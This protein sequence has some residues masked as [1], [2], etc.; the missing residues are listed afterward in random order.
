MAVKE[1]N[2]ICRERL[3]QGSRYHIRYSD[4]TLK[5]GH[6]PNMF[7]YESLMDFLGYNDVIHPKKDSIVQNI[8]AQ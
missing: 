1:E 8:D 7:F 2:H 3:G 5:S 4:K 6:F